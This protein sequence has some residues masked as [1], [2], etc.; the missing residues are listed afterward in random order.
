VDKLTDKKHN[1]ARDAVRVLVCMCVFCDF[2]LFVQK[3]W[4]KHRV[5]CECTTTLYFYVL[6]VVI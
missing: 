3:Q 1:C 5:V 6:C 4:W 2:L